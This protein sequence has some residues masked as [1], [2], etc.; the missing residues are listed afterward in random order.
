MN[1]PFTSDQFMDVFRSYNQ[2]VWPA[3]VIILLIA[4][5]LLLILLRNTKKSNVI[6][7]IGL[8]LFWL[9]MG[10]VYH[11]IFFLKINPAA[12]LFGAVFIL[13]GLLFGYYGVVKKQLVFIY[14][15]NFTG[16][17]S[18]LMF[19]YA[20]I[21]YPLLGYYFGHT[22]PGTP[23]FGLPCPTTIFTFG[24]LVLLEKRNVV[25]H[26]IPLIWS[27]IGFTA[28]LM[29]GVYQDVGLL[30]AGIVSVIVLVSKK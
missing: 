25:L 13:Q 17:F 9:W 10:I 30:I 14:K 26:L 16:L 19:L 28:A 21:F 3:Q 20:L 1:L 29:L 5:Y 22:Y 18:V 2:S 7:S 24:L 11:L 8:S 23:T 4:L 6:I 27:I 15:N 12:Y